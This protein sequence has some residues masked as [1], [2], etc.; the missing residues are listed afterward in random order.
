MKK[1][2]LAI[3]SAVCITAAV[4]AS[5]FRIEPENL[6]D[7]AEWATGVGKDMI[8]GKLIWS[9]RK[10]GPGNTAKGIYAMPESGKYYIW[11]RTHSRGE[12]YRK[13]TVK[14]NGKSIGDFGDEGTKG[15]LNL[16]WKRAHKPCDLTEGKLTLE[17]VPLSGYSRIDSIIFTTDKD[18]T[19][20]DKD[21]D[22]LEEITELECE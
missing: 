8:N 17:L 6:N 7:M 20:V 11:V 19:P 9:N 15:Q 2:F 12:N 21:R 18:F 1:A 3:A 5:E 14:L 13:T 22:T 16:V 10:E 4:G